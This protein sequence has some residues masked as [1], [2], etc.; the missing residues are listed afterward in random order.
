L[1]PKDITYLSGWRLGKMAV[2]MPGSQLSRTEKLIAC[3]WPP[4]WMC[5]RCNKYLY[6]WDL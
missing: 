2:V 5:C 1:P 6:C 3:W 4:L